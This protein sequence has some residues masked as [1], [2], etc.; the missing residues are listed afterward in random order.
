MLGSAP[1]TCMCVGHAIWSEAAR[2]VGWYA[3]LIAAVTFVLLG[4]APIVSVCPSLPTPTLLHAWKCKNATEVA[5]PADAINAGCRHP[6]AMPNVLATAMYVYRIMRARVANIATDFA[7]T[8]IKIYDALTFNV[9][10]AILIGVVVPGICEI[11]SLQEA[12]CHI[13]RRLLGRSW[14]T[15]EPSSS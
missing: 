10:V 14:V 8:Q 11:L 12:A 15:P 3:I 5:M 1:L 7:T 9:S 2:A 6:I 4:R 13:D